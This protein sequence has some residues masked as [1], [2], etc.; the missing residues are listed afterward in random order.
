MLA[1]ALLETIVNFKRLG[2]ISIALPLHILMG[3]LNET[4]FAKIS[5]LEV[6]TS[7][8]YLPDSTTVVRSTIEIH[9]DVFFLKLMDCKIM[10][11]IDFPEQNP[12]CNS[13]YTR[14]AIIYSRTSITRANI[15]ST[16][17][18]R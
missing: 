14:Y 11:N 9:N 17:L 18:R 13:P 5:W 1:A 2:H 8:V 12:P 6:L 4:V 10:L 7:C 3:R 15:F 16:I